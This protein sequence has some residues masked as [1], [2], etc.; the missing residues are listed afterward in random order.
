[1]EKFFEYLKIEKN[2][3]PKTIIAYQNDINSFKEFI[4][5]EFQQ[6]SLIKVNY[7]QIRSWIVLLVNSGISNKTINRKISSLNSFYKFLKKIGVNKINPLNEH[8]SLKTKSIVQIPFSKSE[9]S[10]VLNPEN[11]TKDFDGVRDNLI[12]EILYCTGIRRNELINLKINN[13]DLA[14]QRIKVL[15]KRNKE[16]YIPILNSTVQLL[17]SYLELRNKLNFINDK[18]F[19]LITS[20]GKKIYENL[21][22]RVTKKYFS[23]YSSK[24]KKSPH[25]LRHSFATHLLDNGADLN[26]VKDLL[27]HTSLAATQIYT[28]RSIEEIKKVFKKTHPRNK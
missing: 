17:N 6:S 15:G 19:L 13:I 14:N 9:V 1:L 3:S 10:S 22:N 12:L 23:K 20:R 25:I 21:V 4:S 27:G 5:D 28:N 26:S 11:F 24:L 8:K 16:R 7:S 18:D 2:Y